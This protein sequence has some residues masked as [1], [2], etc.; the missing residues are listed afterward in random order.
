MRKFD[1]IDK[2]DCWCND[3]GYYRLQSELNLDK[4]KT[5]LENSKINIST[6]ELISDNISKKDE[7][8]M[9]V[10]VNYY[11]A[12]RMCVEA[13]LCFDKVNILNHACLFVFLCKNHSDLDLDWDFFEKVR[14][15]RN[16]INYYGEKVSFTD[17]RSIELQMKLCIKTIRKEVKK[18]LNK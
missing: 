6:A 2:A 10:F 16:G 4:V 18:K 12:L 5:L 15:K 11:E 17:W 7:R 13:Y 3:K 8:W 14:T 1:T 9:S